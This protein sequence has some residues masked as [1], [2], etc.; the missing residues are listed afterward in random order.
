[1]VGSKGGDFLARA[2][3]WKAGVVLDAA[4][5]DR[6]RWMRTRITPG[7]RTLDAGCGSGWFAL[8]LASRGSETVG[9]SFDATAN[10]AARRRARALGQTSLTFRDIDLRELDSFDSELGTFDQIICFETIEHILDDRKLIAALADRLNPSGRLLLTTPSAE[11]R[12]LFGEELDLDEQG[13]HVR[14]GTSQAQMHEMLT[15]A[16]LDTIEQ[17]HLCGLITQ[18]VFELTVVLG[19]LVGH[20][21]AAAITVPLRLLWPLDHL[22]TR[23]LSYPFLCI[24]VTAV[25]TP[26]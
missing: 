26:H 24:G 21:A 5:F 15:A 16:G 19:R 10:L 8:Y 4:A 22:L 11:H 23:A 1:M 14:W 7:A 17:N 18:K 9:V 25:K 2:F 12:Q 20:R 3:G 13:G 6:W